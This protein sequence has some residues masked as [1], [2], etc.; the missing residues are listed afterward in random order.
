MNNFFVYEDIVM[1]FDIQVY[2]VNWKGHTKIGQDWMGPSN[3]S[4][5]NPLSYDSP[6]VNNFFV[7]EDIVMKFDIQVYVVNW[8]G[9]TK[10]HQNRIRTKGSS[11]TNLQFWL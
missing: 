1:K 9:H 4:H 10:N 11:H 2:V 5:T 7:Y 3:S 6:Y 8:K